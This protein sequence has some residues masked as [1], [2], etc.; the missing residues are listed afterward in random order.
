MGEALAVIH[1]EWNQAEQLRIEKIGRIHYG[2][3]VH[4]ILLRFDACGLERYL[5]MMLMNGQKL[6]NYCLKIW[7]KLTSSAQKSQEEKL[8]KKKDKTYK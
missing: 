6:E 5:P 7:T 2:T 1:T 3:I 4:R 8:I